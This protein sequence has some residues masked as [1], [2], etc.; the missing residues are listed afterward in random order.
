LASPGQFTYLILSQVGGT[1][2]LP[3]RKKGAKKISH[4]VGILYSFVSR[5]YF[6]VRSFFLNSLQFIYEF[7]VPNLMMVI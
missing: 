4:S 5:C 1:A 6:K 7:N 3:H 2:P